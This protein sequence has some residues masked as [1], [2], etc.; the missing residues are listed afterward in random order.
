M[1][2]IERAAES[3]GVTTLQMMERAGASLASFAKTFMT[4]GDTALILC[5][6]GNNGGDGMAAARLLSEDGYQVEALISAEPGN[7]KG[8]A[9][10]QFR[11]L[12]ESEVAIHAAGTRGYSASLAQI[13]E[14]NVVIDALLGTGSVGAPKGEVL[15][16]IQATENAQGVVISA[17]IPS[18]IECDT[19]NAPG[20]C[21]FADHTLVFGLPKPYLFQ[22]LGPPTAGSWMLGDIGL[23]PDLANAG[24][25]VELL[26]ANWFRSILPPRLYNAHKKSV[27]TVLVVGGS[28]EYT[29]ALTLACHGAVRSGAGLVTAV[30]E[31]A[32]L[33]SVKAHLPECPTLEISFD[34]SGAKSLVDAAKASDAIVIG[35]GLGRKPNVGVFLSE[36]FKRVSD[37]NWVI[38]ADA[39]YWL[40]E[41][42]I[43]PS[44]ESVLTPHEGEAARI[45]GM[46][47]EEIASNR[48]AAAQL[49]AREFAGAVVLK[50]YCSLICEANGGIRISPS[51]TSGLAT[52]GT[53][54]VLSGIIG[55]LF[56]GGLSALDAASAGTFL[57]GAAA[58]MLCDEGIQVGLRASDV[59]EALPQTRYALSSGELEIPNSGEIFD[60]EEYDEF[61]PFSE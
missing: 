15:R 25:N 59:A 20:E 54:D 5:G 56:A 24:G 31:A 43:R 36:V 40:R 13:D 34:A 53:G 58:Q 19:G 35:P 6:P 14:F 49:L 18:G 52:G 28:A 47:A 22:N 8:D 3:F 50:G 45:L 33:Q 27:G 46:R 16:V 44:G 1:R 60:P 9:L 55:A 30:S 38:D 42:G 4:K 37:C 2:E 41:L 10:S 23:P 29:G 7:L 21:V 57:H 39:L 48:F 51:G 26:D 11:Q 32:A 12:A 17:D 61:D